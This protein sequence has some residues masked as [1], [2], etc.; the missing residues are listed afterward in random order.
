MYNSIKYIFKLISFFREYEEIKN[1]SG[2]QAQKLS[3]IHMVDKTSKTVLIFK[4]L[5]TY[6]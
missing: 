3:F 2:R 4:L 5:R 6:D 1:S